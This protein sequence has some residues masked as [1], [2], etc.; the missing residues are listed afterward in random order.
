M[1][2]VHVVRQ[3]K[4]SIGGIEESVYQLCKR[5]SSRFDVKIVTLDTVFSKPGNRLPQTEVVEGLEVQRLP[6]FGSRRYPIAPGVWRAVGDADIVH[7]HAID[8]FFDALAI[9]KPFHRKPLI[10]STH[11]GFFHTNFAST[12][13]KLY[14]QTVTRM[15]CGAYSSVCASGDSDHAMFSRI[16][17]SVRRLGNGVDAR[18]WAGRASRDPVKTL[19][20]FGRLSPNK[21]IGDLLKLAQNLRTTD[22]DWRLIIAGTP[23]DVTPDSIRK[24]I[25]L[26]GLNDRVDLVLE[27]SDGDIGDLIERS[28]FYVSASEHEGFGISVVEAMGAGLVPILSAIPAFRAFVGSSSPG[29]ILRDFSDA[30]AANEVQ[31]V[32]QKFSAEP[33]AAK[34][35]VISLSQKYDWEQIALSFVGLYESVAMSREAD[36][37]RH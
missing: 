32:F 33:E 37:E 8:F 26:A 19:L 17:P 9:T 3:F 12:F 31:Q 7:V 25:D 23:W 1:K 28:S 14:F 22:P 29:L 27:P 36:R 35:A 2:V 21:R 34:H 6:W 11:G 4:P 18:K 15:N 20:Y 10:A 5:L 24:E 30:E 13:K 16:F